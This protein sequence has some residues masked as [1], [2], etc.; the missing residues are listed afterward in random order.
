MRIALVGNQNCGKTTLFNQLTGSNQHVG[1]FPG[2]TV[3]HKVGQYR[4][5]KDIEIIDLPGIY[6]FS[7][8]TP[9]EVVSRDYILKEKPDVVVDVVDATNIERNL[10]LTLQLVE[11]G[12]PVVIALNMMDEVRENGGTVQV[13]LLAEELGIPV[14]PISAVKN[15]GVD[16][17]MLAVSKTAKDH[18]LPKLDFCRGP[19]HDA[20]HAIVHLISEQVKHTS[21]TLRFAATGL[22]EGNPEIAEILELS[23]ADIDIVEHI[24]SD[25]ETHAGTDR[26]A[27]LADMRYSFI[28]EICAKTVKKPEKSKASMLSEKVDK[29]LTGKYTG[30]PIFFCVMIAIFFIT[31]GE[32]GTWLSDGFSGM[33]DAGIAAIG[34]WFAANN[35]SDWFTS[36]A[37]DGVLAGVGSVLS[38]MPIVLMLFF[39]LSL[40]EDSGYMARVAF[41]MDKPLRKLGLS[42]KSIVPM[43]I[44]FGCTVPAVM[45]TRTLASDRDRRFTIMLTPFMSCTAKLPIYAVFT[46]A[47]FPNHGGLVMT[48]LYLFGILMAVVLALV[49]KKVSFSGN[50]IP[51]VMEL[52]VYRMPSWKS[53]AL[54]IWD[55]ASDFLRRAF[56]IILVATVAIWFLQSFDISLNYIED[57]GES[58]LASLG[59]LLAP[60]FAPLGFGDWRACSSLIA[61]LSAK[62]V[63]ISTIEVL[64]GPGETLSSLFT[65]ASAGAFL[66]FVLL[67]M[68][69]VAAY[70]AINSE[71]CRMEQ[72]LAKGRLKAFFFMVYQTALAWVIAFIVYQVLLIIGV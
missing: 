38:F 5:N 50:P 49:L 52:P 24:V 33:I 23:E 65:L 69:C 55:K 37:V 2:V 17:L 56:T 43:L 34:D 22:V 51:F 44:G 58:I 27:A 41:M 12:V 39:F 4:Q 29:I 63:V 3:E 1:N 6:S 36:L 15:E 67:Y 19:V 26:E 46:A 30:I 28:E 54:N 31:F 11:L 71:F 60:V 7:P 66:V 42:G 13:E 68:P 35:I 45:A 9:E 21:L 72:S 47:F 18:I 16:E 14:V 61:G 25:M 70:S 59:K 10:Y 32:I 53:I 20:I 64:L 40:L 8:Y 62:E 57:N 48:L